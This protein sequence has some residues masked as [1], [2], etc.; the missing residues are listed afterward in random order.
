MTPYYTNDLVTLYHGDCREVIPALD[1]GIDLLLTDPPYSKVVDC[2]W[3]ALTHSELGDLLRGVFAAT[4]PKLAGNAALYCFCWPKFAAQLEMLMGDY[5]HVLSHVV[6]CKRSPNGNR[7]DVGVKASLD[8]MRMYRPETERIIFAEMPGADGEYSR[9]CDGIDDSATATAF[10]PLIAYFKQAKAESGLSSKEIQDKMQELT[11]KRYVFDRHTFSASQW[12]MPTQEQYEAAA[13]FMP[14]RREYEALRRYHNP[15]KRNCSDFWQYEPV[16]P[17]NRQRIHP[18]QKP[19]ALIADMV[20]TS[21]RPGGVV[22][23]PFAG[24]GTTGVAAMIAKRRAILMEQDEQYCE[25]TAKR[26][27]E[28]QRQLILNL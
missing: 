16:K 1:A 10:A 12:E 28:H 23:D 7:N 15:S 14:L 9:A 2:E 11:G 26:L 5:F 17:G 13:T 18:T 21:C 25:A 20:T 19:V 4:K 8:T 3:D 6:W 27:E 22:L 24:G